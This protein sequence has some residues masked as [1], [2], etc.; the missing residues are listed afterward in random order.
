MVAV[1]FGAVIEATAGELATN[2]VVD[3]T[4]ALAPALWLAGGAAIVAGGVM[5]F[6]P[7]A[8]DAP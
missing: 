5:F 3:P 2:G 7:G 6:S 8:T 4:D 1:A